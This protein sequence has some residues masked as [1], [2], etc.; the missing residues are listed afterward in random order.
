M[1]DSDEEIIVNIDDETRTDISA[2]GKTVDPAVEE[3]KAQY[4]ELTKKD[5]ARE[6]QLADARRSADEAQRTARAATEEVAKARTEV[7]DS[8]YDTVETGLSAAQT[9][10]D[11]A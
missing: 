5:E 1:A 10:A 2:D 4:A 8:Q 9:E 3:L 6:R 11:S 7:V